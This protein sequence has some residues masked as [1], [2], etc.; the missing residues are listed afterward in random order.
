MKGTFAHAYDVATAFVAPAGGAA[1]RGVNGRYAATPLPQRPARGHTTHR[2]DDAIRRDG[3]GGILRRA[4]VILPM[5]EQPREVRHHIV[6][7]AVGKAT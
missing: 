7:I 3:H 6:S 5:R 1:C 4:V 2:Q